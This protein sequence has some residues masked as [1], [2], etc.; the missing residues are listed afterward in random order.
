M[1]TKLPLN[2]RFDPSAMAS[3]IPRSRKQYLARKL[4]NLLAWG[5]GLNRAGFF[6]TE[7][8]QAINPIA[9]VPTHHGT[10]LCR[11]GHGRLLWRAETFY[12]EEPDTVAWLDSLQPDDVLW[13]I[14]A[15]VGMYSIYA[16]KMRGCQ[17]FAFEPESQN[18]ALLIENIALNQIGDRCHPACLAIADRTG[19]G[20]MEIRSITKGGAY[21]LYES[22]GQRIPSED[23]HLPATM[24]PVRGQPCIVEQIIFGVSLDTLLT[25]Y[26][27]TPPTHLK[28]DVDGLEPEIIDGA[29]KLLESKTLRSILI[30][31]N[32][33]SERDVEIPNVL[34]SHGFQ[35]IS[36]ELNWASRKD[37]PREQ[38]VP[39][40][41]MIFSRE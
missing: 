24:D 26:N 40:T 30:E 1:V 31:I 8:V 35:L 37:L 14:G 28:V 10:L 25:Q 22:A 3:D 6:A 5:S 7:F 12:T 23:P 34:A 13:D 41:N 33:K 15:N 20:T 11:A 2:K 4:A 38:E 39:C 9:K 29:E 16:S 32:L 17:V 27:F 18:Y 36:E 21:T 19:M